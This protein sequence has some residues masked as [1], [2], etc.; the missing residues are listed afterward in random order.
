MLDKETIAYPPNIRSRG[1][2][3]IPESQFRDMARETVNDQPHNGAGVPMVLIHSRPTKG[4]LHLPPMH[5]LNG[6]L[7][8]P[9]QTVL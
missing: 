5:D 7:L 9:L 1:L 3:F 2:K 6:R 4:Y 8:C